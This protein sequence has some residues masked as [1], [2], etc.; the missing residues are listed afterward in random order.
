MDQFNLFYGRDFNN[1]FFK[2][3]NQKQNIH[4]QQ[5]HA[6]NKID[7]FLNSIYQ[8]IFKGAAGS[9]KTFLSALL[10]EYLP[11]RTYIYTPTG[12]KGYKVYD[13]R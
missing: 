4:A 1:A 9:G 3:I 11:N 8:T 2:N 10:R 6:V 7:E 12:C 5:A 13:S